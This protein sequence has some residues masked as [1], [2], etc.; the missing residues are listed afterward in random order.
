MQIRGKILFDTLKKKLNER[1]VK[2][3]MGLVNCFRVM[4]K[5]KNTLVTL[6]KFKQAMKDNKFAFDEADVEII[7]K[8]FD[9]DKDSRIDVNDFFRAL[10]VKQ[11]SVCDFF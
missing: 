9:K 10:I 1:G 5:E 4:E 7:F 11:D 3:V 6:D 2:G 8:E